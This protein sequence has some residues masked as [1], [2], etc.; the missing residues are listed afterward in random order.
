MTPGLNPRVDRGCEHPHRASC[1]HTRSVENRSFRLHLGLRWL[2]QCRSRRGISMSAQDHPSRD[3]G[4]DRLAVGADIVHGERIT[5]RVCG[6]H[7]RSWMSPRS[8]SDHPRVCGEHVY[9]TNASYGQY[10]S[11]PRVRGAHQPDR[12]VHQLHGITPACTGSTSW[13]LRRPRNRTDHPRVYGE[14]AGTWTA[15][16][17]VGGS[18]PRVRGG[19]Q[20]RPAVLRPVRITPAGTGSAAPGSCPRADRPDRPRAAGEQLKPPVQAAAP[21]RITPVRTG[22]TDR[23][24]K[25]QE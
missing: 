13:R 3:L 17:I 9:D 11:P 6:D 4:P 5:P 15:T 19:P 22:S 8:P 25:R 2:N 18:P 24:G 16:W 10:G 14:H 20:A 7:S 12:Q 1:R 23:P 21:D